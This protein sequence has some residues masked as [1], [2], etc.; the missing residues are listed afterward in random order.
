MEEKKKPYFTLTITNIP[1]STLSANTQ[2]ARDNLQQQLQQQLDQSQIR[3]Q[4]VIP[5]MV[6]S[7][8]QAPI[9]QPLQ[10]I[11]AQQQANV[12]PVPIPQQNQQQ[13]P[14]QP[15]KGLSLTVGV[16]TFSHTTNFGLFQTERVCIRQF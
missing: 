9:S 5:H 15:K 8:P 2:Q 1:A 10:P 7:Q 4:T 14:A 11:P 6:Q 12:Q 16:L 13:Q 3:T